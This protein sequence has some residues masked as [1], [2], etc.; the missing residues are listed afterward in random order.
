MGWKPL[1]VIQSHFQGIDALRKR[2]SPEPNKQFTTDTVRDVVNR[3]LSTADVTVEET[4]N[5]LMALPRD[6]FGEDTH[7]ADLLPRLA[8]QYSKSDPGSLV[9]L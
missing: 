5:E 6:T 9:A 8:G 2:F 1:Q 3:I 4:Q 7:I